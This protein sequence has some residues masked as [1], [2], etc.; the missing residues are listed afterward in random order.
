MCIYWNNILSKDIKDNIITE[1]S[2]QTKINWKYQKTELFGYDF[3]FQIPIG[4]LVK[5]I[6][7]V[8]TFY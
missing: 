4:K 7:R 1:I 5:L 3:L 6:F 2:E 8:R